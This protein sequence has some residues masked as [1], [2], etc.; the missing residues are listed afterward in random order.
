MQPESLTSSY[1]EGPILVWVL[2]LRMVSPRSPL[3]ITATLAKDKACSHC[4]NRGRGIRS[5]E[6]DG[7]RKTNCKTKVREIAN[8]VMVRIS[9]QLCG[10]L[11]ST[12]LIFTRSL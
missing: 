8:V 12:N 5:T 6:R 1:L 10:I 4:G 7:D 2:T 9:P 11:H 3:A